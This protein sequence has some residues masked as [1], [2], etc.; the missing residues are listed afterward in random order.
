M[1]SKS[2]CLYHLAILK[3]FLQGADSLNPRLQWAAQN[4]KF[5]TNSIRKFKLVLDSQ[6]V[7]CSPKSH[8]FIYTGQEGSFVI[9]VIKSIV[10]LGFILEV[11]E[12]RRW[13]LCPTVSLQQP[14]PLYINNRVRAAPAIKSNQ[15]ANQ[16]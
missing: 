8:R 2:C 16:Q 1:A 13:A 12:L 7:S 15:Q 9:V 3:Y 5:L 10:E 14:P 6:I 4:Q 11:K